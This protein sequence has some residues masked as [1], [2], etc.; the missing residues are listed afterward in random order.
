MSK[1]MHRVFVAGGLLA[2]LLGEVVLLVRMPWP[3]ALLAGVYLGGFALVALAAL[4]Y[5]PPA[6]EEE[7]DWEGSR[8]V[9]RTIGH[10]PAQASL[11]DACR[12]RAGVRALGDPSPLAAQRGAPLRVRTT[13]KYSGQRAYRC[14]PWN[15]SR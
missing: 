13:G 5:R 2:T 8:E 1:L 4:S 6:V 9:P 11:V 12:V 15:G 7:E 14:G 10:C 3:W